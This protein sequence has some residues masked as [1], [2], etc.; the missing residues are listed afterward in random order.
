MHWNWLWFEDLIHNSCYSD[1]IY[2]F[3]ILIIF[4]FIR[5]I[6]KKLKVSV[7]SIILLLI[8]ILLLIGSFPLKSIILV[9][10]VFVWKSLHPYYP[11]STVSNV[12]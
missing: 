3:Y 4:S 5:H 8:Q 7:C 1:K 10:S 12:L 9:C 6:P 11:N 2:T